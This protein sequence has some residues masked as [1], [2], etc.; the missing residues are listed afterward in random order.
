MTRKVE[1]IERKSRQQRVSRNHH[2]K[3]QQQQQQQSQQRHIP[4]GAAYF[5]HALCTRATKSPMRFSRRRSSAKKVSGLR[6]KI[7]V[8]PSCTSSFV[9]PSICVA[10][11]FTICRQPSLS[12]PYRMRVLEAYDVG[13]TNPEKVFCSC[14]LAKKEW[15][16]PTVLLTF[17]SG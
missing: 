10:I 14:W 6:T 9:I 8:L 5:R 16:L 12:A 15:C 7:I 1:A 3:Q 11:A 2:Y 13:S 17:Q 4:P